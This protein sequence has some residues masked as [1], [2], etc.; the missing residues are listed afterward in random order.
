MKNLKISCVGFA[1]AAVASVFTGSSALADTWFANSVQ[2]ELGTGWTVPTSSWTW[3]STYGEFNN[4]ETPLTFNATD[5]GAGAKSMPG[6]IATIS[7]TVKFTAMDLADLETPAAD[8]KGGLTVVETT[9]GDTIANKYYGIVNGAWAELDGT[10]DLN[11][12]VIVTITLS[13]NNDVT[14]ITYTAGDTTLYTGPTTLGGTDVTIKQVDYLGRCELATLAGAAAKSVFDLSIPTVERATATVTTNGAPVVAVGKTYPITYGTGPIVISYASTDAA[15]MLVGDKEKT[16]ST[17]LAGDTTL[18]VADFNN[19]DSKL[20]IAKIGD[21]PYESI[22]AAVTAAVAPAEITLVADSADPVTIGK[23]LTFS[24]SDV[25]VDG[26]ITMT[27]GGKLT[28]EKGKY[29]GVDGANDSN[30]IVKGGYFVQPPANVQPFCALGFFAKDYV[31]VPQVYNTQI[32]EGT[33]VEPSPESTMPKIAIDPTVMEIPSGTDPVTYLAEEEANGQPRWINYALS[34][35]GTD[36]DNVPKFEDGGSATNILLTLSNGEL[37]EGSGILVE[38]QSN[39]YDE[40]KWVHYDETI[41]VVD[42][43]DY[44]DPYLL[45]WPVRMVVK[46]RKSVGVNAWVTNSVKEFSW[47]F[48]KVNPANKLDVIYVPFTQLASDDHQG[49]RLSKVIK[50]Q[51]LTVGDKIYRYNASAGANEEW[52]LQEDGTWKNDDNADPVVRPGEGLWLERQQNLGNIFFVGDYSD[53]VNKRTPVSSGKWG[54]VANPRVDKSLS[55]SA[56]T[57]NDPNLEVTIDTANGPKVCTYN[58]TDWGYTTVSNEVRTIK[59]QQITIQRTYRETAGDIAPG[60]GFWVNNIGAEAAE[61]NW[62]PDKK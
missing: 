24:G 51:N 58:G 43:E 56:I 20:I 31:T 4:F 26:V 25:A 12:Q 36:S 62:N 33:V 8:V 61:L 5:A 38:Y 29:V 28:I 54:L 44:S 37:R 17:D 15:Y 42:L 9:D 35:D 27:K 14:T 32:I 11:N 45:N 7:T 23:D 18:T 55:L 6:D 41:P 22:Q 34:I 39:R 3:K 13:K 21:T 46:G 2:A 50:A 53:N 1:L 57:D 52:K 47:S 59:G 10:P 30:V 16:I 19:L 40:N 48:S 49:L 60:K